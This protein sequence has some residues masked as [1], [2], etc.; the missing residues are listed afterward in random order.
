MSDAHDTARGSALGKWPSI[1][2]ELAK[3]R[4]SSL[5][6]FTTSAGYAMAG[7]PFDLAVLAPTLVGTFLASASAS[8]LNQIY[9]RDRDGRMRRTM[10]RPLPAGHMSVP[11]ALA[12]ALGSGTAGVGLLAAC[13]NPLTAAL[14]LANIA[15]YAAVYTPLKVRSHRNTEVGAIVGALPPLMGW[16]AA[17]NSACG[18]EP[19][20]LGACLFLWQMPHFYALAWLYRADYA[21]GGY[22]MLPLYDPTGERTASHCLAYALAL[23]A[24]PVATSVA[25][26]TS[27]MFAVESIAFN[28]ALVLLAA[29]FRERASQGRAR[30]LFLYSL[31][32]LPVMLVLLVF[33]G[34][35]LQG[36]GA[37]ESDNGARALPA[38]ERLRD[39]GRELCA[40]ERIA[41]AGAGGAAP[42][43][44]P[45]VLGEAAS[46]E[47]ALQHLPT[48]RGPA[49]E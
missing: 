42:T 43:A 19:L 5:V 11:H 16:T 48:A 28:G 45:I 30:A 6:V 2:L 17:T 15:L 46:S 10:R 49:A 25:G 27:S 7:P 13:A 34:E 9:E 24:L 32:Q 4:L 22:K 26:V 18:L 36:G 39:A 37:R 29:R 14:G 41:K 47:S 1:Y 31:I 44:C 33:H 40:H 35:R 12:F 21:A 8:C 38:V 3:Y 20:A 23:S